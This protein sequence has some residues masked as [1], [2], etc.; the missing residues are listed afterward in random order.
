MKTKLKEN[1]K[2]KITSPKHNEGR[3]KIWIIYP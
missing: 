1:K 2:R 3:E